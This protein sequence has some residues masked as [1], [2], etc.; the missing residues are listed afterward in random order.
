M[1]RKNDD[2]C[3][4]K[5]RDWGGTLMND[6]TEKMLKTEMK[7]RGRIINVKVDEVELPTGTRSGREVVEH[8]GAVAVIAADEDGR[9]ILV[10]QYRYP[11]G[12]TLLEIPAGK[13]DP[14]ESPEE[15]ALRE[16]VEE[17]GYRPGR[18]ALLSRI[19]TTPGF[20]N[21]AIHLFR[22][23][24]LQYVG[25]PDRDVDADEEEN[26]NTVLLSEREAVE[27]IVAREIVDAKTII[28]L[29]WP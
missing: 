4:N 18:L 24:D 25:K 11:V 17:T 2:R 20:S 14:G 9:I 29:L 8:P 5:Y 19:Y 1:K 27:K 28:A 21:E 7:Y 26:L 12:E 23:Y 22:G 6:L 15:C 3:E 10:E 16:M 13:L